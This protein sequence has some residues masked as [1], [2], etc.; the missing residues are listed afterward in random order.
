MTPDTIASEPEVTPPPFSVEAHDAHIPKLGFGT[1]QLTGKTGREMVARAVE[2]G[3]R[4]I[5]TAQ[6]YRNEQDVGRG[7][8]ESGVPRSEVFL[9]TKVGPGSYK[10][11]VL[12]QSVKDSLE[13]LQMDAVDLL[14]LHWPSADVPLEETIAALNDVRAQGIT[15]HIGVSNFTARMVDR[16]VG[17]SAAPLVTNQV[18]Y[19]PYL[20]QNT[21]LANLRGHRMVLTAYCPLGQGR[22]LN[23]SEI[24]AIATR[25]GR[26]P[27]Q[28]ILRW[29]YQQ[30][31]VV[32]I[33]RT[34]NLDHMRANL[35][36]FGFS[37]DDDE[38]ARLSS[39]AR[40]RGRV[41]DPPG[42]SSLWDTD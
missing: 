41:V 21:L 28:V 6:G 31:D 42:M 19:H 22:V 11:G 16:A 12:Q 8:R 18:E 36:I 17:A 34:S 32:A 35:D 10:D 40:P 14:L 30:P 20:S 29:H 33:P 2:A 5:D 3:Y 25:H 24:A 9:T 23:D 15:R 39:L 37:L 7:I 27:S 13:R 26:H 1:F 4:H 38:M